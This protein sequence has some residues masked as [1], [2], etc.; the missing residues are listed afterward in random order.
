MNSKKKKM[1]RQ[2]NKLTN[3]LQSLEYTCHLFFPLFMETIGNKG[4]SPLG[5]FLLLSQTNIFRS[6][7]A[8]E[9][10]YQGNKNCETTCQ[11]FIN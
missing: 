5:S 1:S 9:Y 10:P 4:S 3:I 8:S 11:D 6:N 2:E 7:W